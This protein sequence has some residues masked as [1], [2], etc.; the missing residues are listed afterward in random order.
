MMRLARI[1]A[2]ATA[3]PALRH[4]LAGRAGEV[5]CRAQH[6]SVSSGRRQI[7][8]TSRALAIPLARGLAAASIAADT[9]AAVSANGHWSQGAVFTPDSKTI[10]GNVVEKDHRVFDWTG[11]ALRDT[12]HRVKVNGGPAG[13]RAAE[14]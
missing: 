8:M 11:G 3:A 6:A 14:E 7:A 1:L 2:G 12:G 5:A 13:I 9:Q 4:P 10:V